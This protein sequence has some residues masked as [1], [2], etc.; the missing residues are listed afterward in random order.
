LQSLF[1]LKFQLIKPKELYEKN[2]SAAQP[3]KNQRPR[4]P[5]ADENQ[6]GEKSFEKE[7]TEGKAPLNRNGSKSIKRIMPVLSDT[8]FFENHHK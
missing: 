6:R 3:Q 2:L 4:L 8:V 7:K 1:N 5:Q